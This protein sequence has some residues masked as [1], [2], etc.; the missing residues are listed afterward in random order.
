[1]DFCNKGGI[2][3]KTEVSGDNYFISSIIIQKDNSSIK[4]HENRKHEIQV[5]KCQK[6]YHCRGSAPTTPSGNLNQFL[7]FIKVLLACGR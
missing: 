4:I 5:K 7:F 6:S 3:N 2:S 1:M